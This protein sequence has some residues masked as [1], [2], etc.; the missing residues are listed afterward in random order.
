MSN[1]HC[2]SGRILSFNEFLAA[3]RTILTP[4]VPTWFSVGPCRRPSPRCHLTRK[5]LKKVNLSNPSTTITADGVSFTSIDVCPLTS[6]W[7]KFLI[8]SFFIV[9]AKYQRNVHD[10]FDAFF[11]TTEQPKSSKSAQLSE[12]RIEPL[13]TVDHHQKN[14]YDKSYKNPADSK[15]DYLISS[16][17]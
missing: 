9:G 13:K 14:L 6:F 12:V 16:L 4:S 15:Y 11:P 8:L 2:L 7:R 5:R 17:L 3:T 1:L 10:I